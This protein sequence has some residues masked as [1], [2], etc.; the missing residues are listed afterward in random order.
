MDYQPK[1][2]QNYL[3][4]APTSEVFYYSVY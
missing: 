3:I 2:N 4:S 1:L